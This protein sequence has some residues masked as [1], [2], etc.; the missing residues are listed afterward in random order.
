MKRAIVLSGGGSKGAYQ[1]GVWKALRKLKISYDIVT[2]TSVGALNAALMTQKTYYKALWFWYNIGF[3]DV[4]DEVV[5]D[6]YNTK[7]GKKDIIKKYFK[8]AINGG[9][10]ISNLENTVSKALNEKKIYK[11]NVDLGIITV[12]LKTMQPILLTK[13]KIKK[14]KLKDYLVASASCFP[15]FNKKIIDNISYIDGGIY[16]NLPINLAI[17]MGATEVIA[18]DLNEI[19]I[20]QKI[21]NEQIDITY[22]S[23]NNDIGSFLVF[24]KKMSRRAIRLGYNDAMKKFKNFEGDKYTFK[25]NSLNLN[26]NKYKSKFLAEFNNLFDFENK[27]I[28]NKITKVTIFRKLLNSSD[29][30]IK[31]EFNKLFENLGYSFGLD[32]SFIYSS[33]KYNKMIIKN[34]SLLSIDEN[35][36]K[37]M[38]GNKIKAFLS[39]KETVKYIYGLIKEKNKNLNKYILFFPNEF[40]QALYLKVIIENKQLLNVKK[41][42]I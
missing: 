17:D 1:I 10:T 18:V 12:K 29:E 14:E 41:I 25:F 11:S 13:K 32:D 28:F 9:M 42:K 23:P 24:D 19:G 2:G 16:D 27:S 7:N 20:K 35:I 39:N 15:V 26:Y 37:N 5:N 4:I 30:I 38:N 6:D 8:K 31:K 40:L 21:K 34:F 33:V 36:R 3:N 22:I